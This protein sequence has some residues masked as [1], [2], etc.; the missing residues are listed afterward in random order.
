[1]V[2]SSDPP[3]EL[4]DRSFER[5]LLVKPSSLGDVIHALPVLH[6]LREH[7]PHARI[8]WLISSSIAPLLEGHEKLNDLLLFDRK[9]LG[10]FGR[11][12]GP[13]KDLIRFVREIRSRRYDLVIDLQGLLRSG[14]M[15]WASGAKV[16]V[17]F[18]SA[19]EGA[20]ML[21]THCIDDPD[22]HA[23]DRNMGVGK[24]LGWGDTVACFG[25]PLA[26][27]VRSDTRQWLSELGI[28][29]D[30]HLVVVAPGARWETKVWPW[31]RFAEVIN[32]LHGRNEVHCLL[33]GSRDEVPLCE[34]VAAQCGRPPINLAGQ[35]SLPQLAAI[36]S[37]AD[38]VLCH[39]SASMHLAV[40]LDRP[41]VCITGPTNPIR[42]GPYH[43]LEDVVRVDLACSPCYLRQLS[44]CRHDHRC[45][46]ELAVANVLSSIE[47][48][49]LEPVRQFE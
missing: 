27:P 35:T 17:G 26:R 28:V 18:K 20:A 4:A 31:D 7:Y 40:A 21:Y 12:V 36:V 39:D 47:R 42:T 14:L 10:R 45:M 22:S 25:F 49:L 13:T 16:R 33:I 44:Q 34:R 9:Q 43:R 8:D 41:L 29:G 38:L 23:V 30:E 32:A 19:R 3:Q 46:Q 2:G 11:G 6:A 15:A 37:L 1:V 48:R 24:L 5:I